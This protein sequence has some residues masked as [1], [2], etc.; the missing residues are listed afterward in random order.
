MVRVATGRIPAPSSSFLSA[1]I[2]ARP[3]D[4]VFE[5]RED[6]VYGDFSWRLANEI[7][8]VG[9]GKFMQE[10]PDLIEGLDTLA[11]LRGTQTL[12]MDLQTIVK[13]R[14]QANVPGT[15]TFEK[16]TR[17]TALQQRALYLLGIRL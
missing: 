11:A 13:N 7:K 15:G 2:F 17:P 4:A 8:R 14:I 16:I 10:F 9:A 3:E 1:P 5:L 6:N 12:L